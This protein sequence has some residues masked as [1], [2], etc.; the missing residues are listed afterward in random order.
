[1][2]VWCCSDANVDRVKGY[3]DHAGVDM[4]MENILS[5]DMCS[6]GKPHPSVY[7]MARE[8]AGSDKEG[9]VSVF[10]AAHAWDIAAAKSAGCVP[11]SSDVSMLLRSSGLPRHG[12]DP[13]FDTAYCLIYENDECETI[14][15]KADLVTKDLVELGKGIVAKWGKK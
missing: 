12:S 3:F 7:K 14:F 4:P 15:G 13:S 9:E 6:S 1:L 8:K 10:A 11:L 5:A 2:Q